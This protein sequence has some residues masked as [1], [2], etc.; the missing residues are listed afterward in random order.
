MFESVEFDFKKT[1]L[2]LITCKTI[3]MKIKYLS[4]LFFIL[5]LS[6][7]AAQAILFDEFYFE[8][9]IAEAKQILKKNQK[10]LTNIAFGAKTAYAFRKK[11]LVK[12]DDILISLNLWSKNNLT[13]KQ[14]EKYLIDARAH[15]EAN[16]Y[17]T[18]YAQ[19]NWSKPLLVKK[20]LPCI[21]FVDPDKKTVVEIDPRGQG[22]V[23]NI[24]VTYYNY[25]WFLKKARGEK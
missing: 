11:S 18:V 2:Y 24:F 17:K 10:A 4:I 6:K 3:K 12:E 20:N 25:D 23:F 19:E 14:A 21:R 15:F 5:C 22:S 7:G 8:M 13:L 1:H 16:K 9:P